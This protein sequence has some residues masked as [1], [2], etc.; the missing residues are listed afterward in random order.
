MPLKQTFYNT[1]DVVDPV[2]YIMKGLMCKGIYSYRDRGPKGACN[3]IIF[4]KLYLNH[5]LKLFRNIH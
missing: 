2:M 1:P 5:L 4:V 3:I